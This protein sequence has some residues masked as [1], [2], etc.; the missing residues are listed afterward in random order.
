MDQNRKENGEKIGE[1]GKKSI[2]RIYY[3][4]KS[5]LKKGKKYK[6]NCISILKPIYICKIYIYTVISLLWLWSFLFHT[7]IYVSTGN[8]YLHDNMSK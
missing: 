7:E 6:L 5:F 2:S 1:A 3:M 8:K 4:K